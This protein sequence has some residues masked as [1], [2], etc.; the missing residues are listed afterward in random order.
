MTD[1]AIGLLVVLVYVG[2]VLASVPVALLALLVGLRT[3]SYRRALGYSLGGALALLAVGAV[4]LA[5]AVTPLAGATL[6]GV[7]VLAVVT[8]G[9]VPLVLGRELVVRLAGREIDPEDALKWT[10]AGWPVALN[11]SVAVFVAPGG[12]AR[13]N[14]TFLTGLEGIL[15]VAALV[16]VVA[17]GPGLV[18]TGLARAFGN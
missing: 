6:L 3:G 1:V 17:L 10:V 8:L 18:G 9:V 7:G 11:V 13:Y 15:S 5:V 14:V 2:T 16:G 12:P 4:A